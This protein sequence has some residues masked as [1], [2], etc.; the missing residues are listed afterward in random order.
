MN[1]NL[2]RQQQMEMT[3]RQAQAYYARQAN[4]S[5]WRRWQQYRTG[6]SHLPALNSIPTRSQ[7]SVKEMFVALDEIVGSV[8]PGRAQD[9]DA[10]FRPRSQHTKTRWLAIATHLLSGRQLPPVELVKTAQGYFISDG[11]HRVSVHKA[12]GRDEIA[13]IVAH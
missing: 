3:N 8:N 13:A 11:H 5:I 2:G 7:L 9:F 12:L 10:D 4:R 1:T 6:R